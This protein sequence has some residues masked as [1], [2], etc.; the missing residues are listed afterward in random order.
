MFDF[1]YIRNTDN[2]IRCLDRDELTIGE[3]YIGKLCNKKFNW[4]IAVWD[5]EKFVK[6][7]ELHLKTCSDFCHAYLDNY[8]CNE[9]FEKFIENKPVYYHPKS[10]DGT[11]IINELVFSPLDIRLPEM[12]HNDCLHYVLSACFGKD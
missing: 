3:T 2:Y 6:D 11:I 7:T 8:N 5:G 10:D 9:G 4:S 12:S 1:N